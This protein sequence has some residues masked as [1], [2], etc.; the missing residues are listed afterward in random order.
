[1]NEKAIESVLLDQDKSTVK[2]LSIMK[3]VVINMKMYEPTDNRRVKMQIVPLNQLLEMEKVRAQ[4]LI[5]I[6]SKY[7]RD[8]VKRQLEVPFP[9]EELIRQ[10]GLP[11]CHDS[12][13]RAYQW[14]IHHIRTIMN[15]VPSDW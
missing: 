7:Y 6:L 9:E 2:R 4:P 13:F 10:F 1:M 8:T 3:G 14:I 15:R 11:G 12:W 5:N